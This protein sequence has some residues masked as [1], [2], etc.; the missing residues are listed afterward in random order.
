MT[1]LRKAPFTTT[2]AIIVNGRIHVLTPALYYK[3]RASPK[4][5]G[6]WMPA[7]RVWSSC[8]VFVLLTCPVLASNINLFWDAHPAS[9]VTHY[10]I[11]GDPG[12]V[13]VYSI[14]D[15]VVAVPFPFTVDQEVDF[16]DGDRC[17]KYTAVN[18]A[19][20]ESGFS[21]ELRVSKPTGTPP[22]DPTPFTFTITGEVTMTVVP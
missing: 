21:P 18:N 20:L 15:V 3:D 10:N 12:C 4:W 8:L 9:N 2:K 7:V 22:A 1:T 19:G 16:A 6:V 13:G 14:I 11:S 5:K 17:Y